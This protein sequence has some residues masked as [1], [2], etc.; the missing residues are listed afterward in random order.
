MI[1]DMEK[2]MNVLMHEIKMEDLV[3]LAARQLLEEIY[4]V[5]L[6]TRGE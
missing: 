3:Q 2:M 1:M 6:D 5:L 4:D